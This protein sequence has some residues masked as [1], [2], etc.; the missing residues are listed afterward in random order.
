MKKKFLLVT[1]AAVLIGTGIGTGVYLATRPSG[2]AVELALKSSDIGPD[3]EGDKLITYY[4][5]RGITQDF[6]KTIDLDEDTKLRMSVYQRIFVYPSAEA[7]LE[8]EY[9]GRVEREYA[10][11][12]DLPFWDESYAAGAAGGIWGLVL[13]KSNTLVILQYGENYVLKDV[14]T[15]EFTRWEQTGLTAEEILQERGVEGLFYDLADIIQG[16]IIEIGGGQS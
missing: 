10:E 9:F 15:G 4:E 6:F 14:M 8:D 7:A 5:G 16:K 11:P 2:P 1:I 3:W 13:R 12:L